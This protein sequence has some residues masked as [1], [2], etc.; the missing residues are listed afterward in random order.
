MDSSRLE[1]SPEVCFTCQQCGDCCRGMAVSLL[2]EEKERL[3]EVDWGGVSSRLAGKPLF[4]ETPGLSPDSPPRFHLAKLEADCIFLEGDGRCLIHRQLG[5]DAKPLVCRL[6]PL[7]LVESPDET[8]VSASFACRA[9]AAGA[10]TPLAQREDEIRSLLADPLWDGAR[11]NGARMSGLVSVPDR[12]V[13]T[14]DIGLDSWSYEAL[15]RAIIEIL[16]EDSHT[17]AVR[18]LAAHRL[19]DGAVAQYGRGDKTVGPFA[20]WLKHM[21]WS[22]TGVQWLYQQPV[23]KPPSF[24]R[25]RSALAPLIALVEARWATERGIARMRGVLGQAVSLAQ[26]RGKVSLPSLMAEISLEEMVR[27]R[28]DQDSPLLQP[29]LLRY[30]REWLRRKGLLM[31]PTVRKGIQYLLVY[32]ALVRWYAVALAVAGGRKEVGPE[33]LREGIRTVERG[34]VHHNLLTKLLG[35]QPAVS[36][37]VN[38]LMDLVAS[39]ADLVTGFYGRS[40]APEV[41]P[42]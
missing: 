17:M 11:A 36:P 1:I 4:V 26:G 33:D 7:A 31:Q 32:F 2:P 23:E 27:V 28:F 20:T 29:M 10:G 38:L 6:F 39:P 41:M 5:Y 25:Q 21:M 22:D 12:I 24:G 8:V 34:Y 16:E 15:E 35:E 37:L 19:T 13:L 3:E 18:L 30:L 14:A 42:S 9:V 40:T